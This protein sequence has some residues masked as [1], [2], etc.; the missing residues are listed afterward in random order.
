LVLLKIVVF[1]CAGLSHDKKFQAV[2]N[3]I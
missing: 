1:A 2:E 3:C